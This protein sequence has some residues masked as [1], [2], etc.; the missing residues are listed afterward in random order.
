M[1]LEGPAPPGGITVTV[2]S[3]HPAIA[4]PVKKT[5]FFPRGTDFK[6]F[7]VRVADVPDKRRVYFKATTGGI[8]A[9]IVV[10]IYPDGDIFAPGFSA[11]PAFPAGVGACRAASGAIE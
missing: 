2:T 7:D 6:T 8:T 5:V 3:S 11:A 10:T 4:S 1:R 9:T